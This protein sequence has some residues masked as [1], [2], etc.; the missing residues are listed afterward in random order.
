MEKIKSQYAQTLIGI[1]KQIPLGSQWII[2]TPTFSVA[3]LI[4]D[5]EVTSSFKYDI[6]SG[7]HT[8]LFEASLTRFQSKESDGLIISY[9]QT[10]NSTKFD[11]IKQTIKHADCVIVDAVY[12]LDVEQIHYSIELEVF[13]KHLKEMDIKTIHTIQGSLESAG[14]TCHVHELDLPSEI[15]QW[16]LN[17]QSVIEYTQTKRT[18]WIAQSW[19][20]ANKISA[21]LHYHDV[22]HALVHKKVEESAK[23]IM[24]NQF[25]NYELDV[26]V[27]TWETLLPIEIQGIDFIIFTFEP[28]SD[29]MIRFFLPYVSHHAQ[30]LM[31]PYF[32]T[33]PVSYF[34]LPLNQNMHDFIHHVRMIDQGCSMR[35]A[36]RSLNIDSYEFEKIIKLLKGRSLI[37]KEGLNYV[38][39]QIEG[40]ATLDSIEFDS[41]S[42]LSI[43]IEHIHGADSNNPLGILFA[44]SPK[45]IMPVGWYDFAIIPDYL[46]HEEGVICA[47]DYD[48][49]VIKQYCEHHNIDTVLLDSK[50]ID[51]IQMFKDEYQV[52]FIEINQ[53]K[54]LGGNNPYQKVMRAKTS[55][56]Q[57][58]IPSLNHAHRIGLIVDHYDEGWSVSAMS[59]ALKTHAPHLVI[60]P[61]CLSF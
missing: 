59:I 2:F 27:I 53:S 47:T 18:L 23:V 4:L 36:E 9:E 44:F 22:K 8:H 12:R 52:Q 10:L 25:I 56:D 24:E 55:I 20:E 40:L 33:Q 1:L 46:K 37:K 5:D 41:N 7:A 43:A 19:V 16:P 45:K 34:S 17:V 51:I 26:C 54:F 21:I 31:M 29:Y 11:R 28:L 30:W 32:K 60:V 13:I 3:S 50:H 48:V 39:D 61:I 14:L 42:T 49:E 6:L 58:K 38:I 57:W 35:E 15:Q